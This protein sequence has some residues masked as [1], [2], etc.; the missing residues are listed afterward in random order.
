MSEIA[1]GLK[2]PTLHYAPGH[3]A[4]IIGNVAAL[5]H[6]RALIDTEYTKQAGHPTVF[7]NTMYLLSLIDRFVLEWAGLDSVIKKHGLV[8]HRPVYA[9]TAVEVDGTVQSVSAVAA[10][11]L[12]GAGRLIDIAITIQSEGSLRT[13]ANASVIIPD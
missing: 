2:L 10:S 7:L 9:G 5:D 1:P 8:I 12:A 11:S 6:H 13:K 3:A 4:V